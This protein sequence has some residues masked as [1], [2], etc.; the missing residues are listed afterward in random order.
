[1]KEQEERR[2]E[3][4]ELLNHIRQVVFIATPH[5]GS[6]KASLLSQLSFLVWPSAIA[7]SL[8]ANDPALR[9]INISYR[10][11]ADDR[12]QVLDHRVFYETRETIAGGIVDE[13]S[14]DPGLH[15]IPIPIDAD[16]I[17]IAKPKDRLSLLY[18]RIREFVRE[19]MGTTSEAGQPVIVQLPLLRKERSFNIG[20]KAMRLAVLGTLA[21]LAYYLLIPDRFSAPVDSENAII[22]DYLTAVDRGDMA[23]AWD[24][25]DV[26]ARAALGGGFENFKQIAENYRVPL[27]SVVSRQPA[28]SPSMMYSPSG[29]PPGIY[30]GIIFRTKFANTAGCRGETIT[31]RSAR[32][33][34]WHIFGHQ[35][36]PSAIEC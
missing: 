25:W 30:R 13:A 15:T 35:I 26:S 24:L 28:G 11:L 10:G 3:A 4:R 14:S 17:S 32:E 16:H 27:G 20:P 23:A 2:S 7:R 34:R 18:V 6:R 1:L 22:N 29:Y 19:A 9:Q 21:S 33:R 5:T 12:R 8:V 31:V 36:S